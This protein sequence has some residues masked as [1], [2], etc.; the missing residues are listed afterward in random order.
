MRYPE[1]RLIDCHVHMR[2]LNSIP[3]L[4]AVM[5]ACGMS[6]INVLSLSPRGDDN[7]AQNVVGLLFKARQPGRVYAFGG[8]RHTQSGSVADPL[9]FEEQARRAVEAGCDGIKMI[10][11]KPSEYKLVNKPLDG[12][13]YEPLYAWLAESGTPLL[14]HVGDPAS[15]WDEKAPEWARQRGWSYGDGTYPTQEELRAQ[16]ARI[17]DR[18]PGLKVIFAHF[19]FMSGQLDRAARF[20]KRHAG[21]YLD[22]TPNGEMYLDL[23]RDPE[24]A[25]GFF[26]RFRDRI[27]FGT[28]NAG[29][30]RTPN[31]DR[32]A[33]AAEKVAAMRRFLE[34]EDEFDCFGG[35]CR[36]LG[37][38][39]DVCAAI[40]AGNFERL[41]G[42]R[43]A[44]VR[45]ASALAECERLIDLARDVGDDPALAG[46]LPAIS[47]EF[48]TLS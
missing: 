4:T 14:L 10:E 1:T 26:V 37:L 3:N 2:G 9:S 24:E 19:Y 12:P 13:A 28:D 40:Y 46:E 29:G 20:L 5:D 45:P 11:G 22:I 38:P 25:H 44:E 23:S 43:P 32:T 34:T 7:L 48:Q 15:L 17:L 35:T 31:P 30:R 18:F 27:L 33:A 42:D 8:L 6:A 47:R 39:R 41:A 21:V 36:G 16:V